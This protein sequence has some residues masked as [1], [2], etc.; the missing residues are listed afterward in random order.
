MAI[1]KKAI[2]KFLN[3]QLNEYYCFIE[4]AK[5]E[6]DFERASRLQERVLTIKV[7]IFEIKKEKVKNLF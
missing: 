2:L 1:T 5:D 4:V 3:K 7:M 6:K